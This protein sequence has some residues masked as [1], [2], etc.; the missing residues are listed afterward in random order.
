MTCRHMAWKV[1]IPSGGRKG[2]AMLI[3]TTA[4]GEV[5]KMFLVK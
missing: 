5:S 4:S 1:T 2:L 3:V